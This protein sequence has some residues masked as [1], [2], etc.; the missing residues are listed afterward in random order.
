MQQAVFATRRYSAAMRRRTA[1]MPA[2]R[3]AAVVNRVYARALRNCPW[4]GQLWGRA[5]RALERSGAPEEEHAAMYDKALAAGLQVRQ[6][7]RGRKGEEEGLGGG[8]WSWWVGGWGVRTWRRRRR[9]RLLSLLPHQRKER[10][11]VP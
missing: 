1:P 4:V 2:P 5:L 11:R 3:P 9:Q 6:A 7:G 10:Q 8:W